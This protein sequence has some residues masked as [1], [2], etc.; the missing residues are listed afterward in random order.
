MSLRLQLK[1]L[2]HENFLGLSVNQSSIRSAIPI[3]SYY[4]WPKTDAWQQLKF[5]L[6]SKPWLSGKEKIRVL[7]DT[8]EIMNYWK[9]NRGTKSIKA[10]VEDFSELEFVELAK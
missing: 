8:A 6:D 1:V 5:E 3:T 10:L 9:K 2:W 4:I 7:N